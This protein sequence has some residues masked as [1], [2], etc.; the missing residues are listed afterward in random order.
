[1]SNL[2]HDQL[3]EC[4]IKSGILKGTLKCKV[5]LNH[6]LE[7]DLVYNTENAIW[8]IEAKVNPTVR[9]LATALGQVLIYG[10]IYANYYK[11]EKPIKLMVITDTIG[12]SWLDV[13]FWA[14]DKDIYKINYLKELFE[15]HGVKLLVRVLDF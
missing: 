6:E 15:K 11:L 2:N 5:K 4:F 8:I 12:V 7:I 9:N 13:G 10:S 14:E 3:V 1:M